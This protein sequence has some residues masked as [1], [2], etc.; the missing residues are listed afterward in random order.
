MLTPTLLSS[1]HQMSG[2]RHTL[3]LHVYFPTY[4]ASQHYYM[5]AL[6]IR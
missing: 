6:A 5:S 1:H 4:I 2:Y 3:L